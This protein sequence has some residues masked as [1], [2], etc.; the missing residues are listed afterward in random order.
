MHEAVPPPK[1][2]RRVL[3]RPPKSRVRVTCR[4][5]VL[6]LGPNLA[7][8]VVDLSEAGVRLLLNEPLEPGQLVSVGLEGQSHTRPTV[9][10][11]TVIWRLPAADGRHEVGVFFEKALPYQLVLELTREPPQG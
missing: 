3:R 1:N 6:D 5:G 7:L 9:R 8:S 2:R 10:V 4:R 11:G